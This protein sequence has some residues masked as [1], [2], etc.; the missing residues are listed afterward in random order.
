MKYEDLINQ[1]KENNTLAED[2]TVSY[3]TVNVSESCLND[4][5]PYTIE[6]LDARLEQAEKD[7]EAGRYISNESVFAEL[8]QFI[9][10]L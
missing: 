2:A 10:A 7:F 1:D 9:Q 5:T 8:N 4:N 3:K 6:E